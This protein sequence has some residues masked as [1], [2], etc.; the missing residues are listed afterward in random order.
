MQRIFFV[1]FAAVLP[2]GRSRSMGMRY[3][4]EAGLFRLSA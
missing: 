4:S 2:S 1:V 3:C